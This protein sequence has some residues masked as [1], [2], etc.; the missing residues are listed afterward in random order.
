[1]KKWRVDNAN[2]KCSLNFVNKYKEDIILTKFCL[3][4]SKRTEQTLNKKIWKLNSK[5]FLI[6]DWN[7]GFSI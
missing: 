5:P 1:M 7:K 4:V 3:S 2:N 6:G